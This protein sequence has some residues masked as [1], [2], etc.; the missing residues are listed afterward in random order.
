VPANQ[1]L[2][3]PRAHRRLAEAPDKL[4]QA[5]GERDD[6]HIAGQDVHAGDEWRCEIERGGV[7]KAEPMIPPG[8]DMPPRRIM[9]SVPSHGALTRISISRSSQPAHTSDLMPTAPR[10]AMST[11]IGT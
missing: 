3:D 4:G 8:S 2:A 1:P 11:G 6:D 10:T 5:L 9:K 7:E